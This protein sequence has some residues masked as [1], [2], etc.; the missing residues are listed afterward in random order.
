VLEQFFCS[1]P[2]TTGKPEFAALG[3]KCMID[4]H[5]F[6]QAFTIDI[7]ILIASWI[8]ILIILI[9]A[10][11]LRKGLNLAGDLQEVP[12]KRQAFLEGIVLFFQD[13]VSSGFQTKEFALTFFPF[14]ATIGLYILVSNWIG[15]IPGLEPPTMDINVALGMGLVVFITAQYYGLKKKGLHRLKEFLGPF[16]N[17]PAAIFFLFLEVI[18]EFSKLLSHSFRL[19]GNLNGKVILIGVFSVLLPPV[20]YILLIFNGVFLAAIQAMVFMLLAIV[21]ISL[22]AEGG[23]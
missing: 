11:I 18:G 8:A 3:K 17:S 23:H 21:Y 12:S 20:V 15:L 10:L 6:G 1:H 4:V 13:Q 19:F 5:L 22:A 14:I 2:E 16:P 7:T 9:G